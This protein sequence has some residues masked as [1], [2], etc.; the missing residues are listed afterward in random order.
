MKYLIMIGALC[1]ASA[2]LAQDTFLED[3]SK[4]WENAKE[5]TLEFAKAMPADKYDFKPA[6]EEMTFA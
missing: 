5:Y 1:A 6:D 2:S 3:F 4:K